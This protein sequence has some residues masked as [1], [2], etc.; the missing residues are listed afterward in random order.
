MPTRLRPADQAIERY[1]LEALPGTTLEMVMEPQ[2]WAHCAGHLIRNSKYAG[3]HHEVRVVAADGSFDVL[4]TVHRADPF[5]RWLQMRPI[6]IWETAHADVPVAPPSVRGDGFAVEWG[7][8]AASVL[9]R[10]VDRHRNNTVV[11]QGYASKED[12]QAALDAMRADRPAAAA[13]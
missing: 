12:A 1:F 8:P 11:M 9:W 5:G 3:R 10:I 6:S 7:A 4:L 13:A 2:F